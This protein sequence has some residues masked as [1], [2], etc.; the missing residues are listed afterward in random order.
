MLG[1]PLDKRIRRTLAVTVDDGLALSIEDTPTIYFPGHVDEPAADNG[2]SDGSPRSER[3]VYRLFLG[4][5]GI[6]FHACDRFEVYPNTVPLELIAEPKPV[7]NGRVVVG[8][9]APC[10]PTPILYPR[11]A[12][13][14][15]LGGEAAIAT[16]ECAVYSPRD[17]QRQ[18]GGYVDT[19]VEMPPS[20]WEHLDGLDNP[21]L[22]FGDGSVWTLAEATLGGEVPFVSGSI[23]KVA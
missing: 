22:H 9:S 21:Q 5:G 4:I 6:T 11:S 12:E 15:A 23:R 10:L 18:R 17:S 20:A 19:F 14:W 7:S 8:Y 3:S 2:L 16:V 13:V 1:T